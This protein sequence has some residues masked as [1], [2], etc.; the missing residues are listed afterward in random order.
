MFHSNNPSAMFDRMAVDRGNFCSIWWDCMKLLRLRPLPPGR[1][2]LP[3][4]LCSKK[5][6]T[7]LSTCDSS[8]FPVRAGGSVKNGDII[9]LEGPGLIERFC[10]GGRD[11]FVGAR[12]LGWRLNAEF[13]A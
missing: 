9:V 7:Y 11:G 5:Y 3:S 6:T 12:R 4:L 13:N 1:S 8:I 2:G 10:N